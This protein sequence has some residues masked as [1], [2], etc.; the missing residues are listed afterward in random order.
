MVTQGGNGVGM[1]WG[2]RIDAYTLVWTSQ[3]ALVVKTPPAS[4]GDSRKQV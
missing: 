4:A 3:I 2:I 1:N